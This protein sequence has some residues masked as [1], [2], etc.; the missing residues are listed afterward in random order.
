MTDAGLKGLA[1]L[2]NLTR[3]DLY[4][5]KVSGVGLEELA[6]TSLT[7]INLM[8]T[9]ATDAGVKG[10]ALLKKLTHLD[11]RD[12]RVTDAGMK[13]LVPLTS[14]TCLYLHGTK[15]TNAGLKELAPLKKLNDLFLEDKNVTDQTLSVLREINLLH[16][17]TLARNSDNKRP[18]TPEDVASFS[19]WRT[20]VTDA[21]L[22]ELAALKN[23]T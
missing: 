7:H 6:H 19:L 8:Q 3:L 21:G 1:Q 23:L 10:L 12:T 5:T 18:A 2:N 16:A 15:V 20:Q 14:L 11:L 13:G 17:L 22:K 4:N 9:E